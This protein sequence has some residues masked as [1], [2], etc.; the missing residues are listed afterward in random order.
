MIYYLPVIYVREGT[1]FE[2]NLLSTD[3]AEP[4]FACIFSTSLPLNLIYLIYLIYLIF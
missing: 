1:I 3:S 4:S 2:E